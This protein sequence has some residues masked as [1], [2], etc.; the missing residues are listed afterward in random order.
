MGMPSL[1]DLATELVIQ[2]LQ[3][4]N[5]SRSILRFSA[6]S[7]RYFDL[8]KNSTNLQLRIELDSNEMDIVGGLHDH[9]SFLQKLRQY[10][11]A[12]IDPKPNKPKHTYVRGLKWA[13]YA[14]LCGGILWLNPRCGPWRML[15]LS[16]MRVE[17]TNHDT[18]FQN[19]SLEQDLFVL[20]S[21]N[22]DQTHPTSVQ[23]QLLTCTSGLPH[24]LARHPMLT[25]TLRAGAR[26]FRSLFQSHSARNLLA[27]IFPY[28]QNDVGS[29]ILVWDWLLGTLLHRIAQPAACHCECIFLNDSHLLVYTSISSHTYHGRLCYAPLLLIYPVSMPTSDPHC[30]G[31]IFALGSIPA[32][33]PCLQLEFPEL[34]EQSSSSSTCLLSHRHAALGANLRTRKA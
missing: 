33:E 11:D 13:R 20:L 31:P 30:T 22:D 34:L 21:S 26:Y 10:Q 3:N 27:V 28:H 23:I 6:T 29:D 14:E 8:V 4:C 5:D 25:V 7:W 17:L 24:P 15:H 32:R 16:D 12:C 19:L 18:R 2:I 1:Q 9:W